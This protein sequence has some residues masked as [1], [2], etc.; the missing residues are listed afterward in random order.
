MVALLLV[1]FFGITGITLNHPSWTFGDATYE[2]TSSGTLPDD[3]VVDGIVDF[4]VVSEHVRSEHDVSGTIS[5]FGTT[6]EA[7]SMSF[8]GPGYSADVSFD[9]ETGAYEV[10]T[11]EQGLVGVMN[12]LHKGRD[13]GSSWSWLIDVSG[14]V[15]VLIAATGLG[16]Q[17]FLKKRRRRAFTWAAIGTVASIIAI[18]LAM[19]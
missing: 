16:I 19:A 7:G 2:A 18:W 15:L 3:S 8:K 11:V 12:D 6:G 5:D 9:V 1:L 4:L 14:G 17:F 13:T 10:F